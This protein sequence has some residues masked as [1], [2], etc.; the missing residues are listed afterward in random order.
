MRVGNFL[1]SMPYPFKGDTFYSN[2]RKYNM[3]KTRI[4]LDGQTDNDLVDMSGNAVQDGTG[5]DLSSYG[6]G[7]L[8]GHLLR[9]DG[10]IQL[11]A[12]IAAIESG[13]DKSVTTKE[14]QVSKHDYLDAKIED[15]SAA[16]S[17]AEAS[18]GAL[19]S[20]EETRA[21]AAESVLQANIDAEA[22]AA[23]AA[24]AGI[25]AALD[26]QEA[27]EAA[28]EVSNDAALAAEIARAT[29]A[30]AALQADVNLNEADGDTDRAL[31]RTEM[32][33]NETNR[34]ASV[35]AIRAALQADVD[36]NEADGD[37]DRALIR[38]EIAAAKLVDDAALATELARALAAEAVIQA[39]VDQNELDGDN[40]RAAIRSEMETESLVREGAELALQNR[41]TFLEGRV[42]KEYFVV[43]Q[44]AETD[45]ALSELAEHGSI[46]VFVNGLL[47]EVD[48]TVSDGQG[49]TTT[50]VL[51]YTMGEAAGVSVVSFNVPG[52]IAG[53]RVSVKFDKRLV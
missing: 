17:A 43:A 45:F 1:Y 39:D 36:L 32:A 4:R 38:S 29:A 40:D 8:E 46:M 42:M 51:D 3:A 2:R 27:K 47:Q 20:A 5:T 52:L 13:H 22:V 25:Q 6:V 7:G 34:D 37:T 31:I 24:E 18:L 11:S 44:N 21:T 35:E 26:T 19:I 33:T 12:E 23:R 50:T 15:N 10:K 48:Y 28:Y 41:A 14:W 16:Q 53:D 30:E 49:G 9:A